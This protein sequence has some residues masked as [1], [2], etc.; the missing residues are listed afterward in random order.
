MV[1]WDE[2]TRKDLLVGLA[3]GTIKLFL[4]TGSDTNP[5]FD[6][7]TFLQVGLPGT[8]TN[9]DVGDRAT[10]TV[11][12][13]NSDGKKDLVV[14]ALDGKIR[15]F[16]NEGTDTSPDF[17][18]VTF[19][20]SGGSPLIVPSNRSSPSV[21]DVDRDGKKDLLTGN[22]AGELLLYLN[23]GTDQ[24]PSFS[25]FV[26][27][28]ADGAPIDLPGNPRSRPGACDWTGNGTLDVLIGAADG[29]VRLYQGIPEPGDFDADGDVDGDDLVQFELCCTGP[30]GGPI[31]PGCEPG[32][33][34][35][36][37]NI[38]CDDWVE[39]VLAWDDPGDPPP[40]S[41]GPCANATPAIWTW[42]M[43]LLLTIAVGIVIIRRSLHYKKPGA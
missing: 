11:V 15:V 22:T 8:K 28:E 25:G 43:L 20:Q 5:T 4:N 23:T 3:D 24:A 13:F 1:Y 35:G 30:D 40:L 37:G 41:S 27:V 29:N 14:G 38:D 42:V 10:Q 26:R 16:I 18:A 36:D 9:I 2:D 32:D 21:V 12:D 19:V 39:F 7:G 34:D 6:G 17:R 33:F 31:E